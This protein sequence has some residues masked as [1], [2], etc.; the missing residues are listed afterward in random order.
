MIAKCPKCLKEYHGQISQMSPSTV[1]AQSQHQLLAASTTTASTSSHVP[2]QDIRQT[3]LTCST[4]S[5]QPS[6]SLSISF[7]DSPQGQETVFELY[8]RSQFPKAI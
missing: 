2:V 4:E 6:S 3:T 8:L 7:E 1:I 5:S